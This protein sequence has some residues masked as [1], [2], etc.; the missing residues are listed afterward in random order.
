MKQVSF[1]LGLFLAVCMTLHAASRALIVTGLAA[2]PEDTEEFQ[3]LA[4]ETKRLLVERG[5]PQENIVT[6]PGKVNRD[7][8]LQALQAAQS[9]AKDDEFWLVLY[10]HSGTVDNDEAAFQI[11]GP[12]LTASDLKT[13]LAAIPARQ[14]V[15]IATNSS[16]GFL[17][18]L[19]SSNRNVL[20]ATKG[21]DED[22]QP[23]FPDEWIEA[24]GE[25]PK[26]SFAR[27]AARAATLTEDQY[28]TN[29]LAQTEHA[30]L[31]DATTGTILE[32]PFG[33]DL[34]VKDP[35]TTASSS[36]DKGGQV[37]LS[38]LTIKPHDPN[39]MWEK[40]PASDETRKLIADAQK[41]PNP[42]GDAAIM[43]EQQ[44]GFTVRAD[45]MT[46]RDVAYRVYVPREEAVQ[47]WANCFLPQSAP[48]V[49]TKLI[50]ARVINPDGSSTI[51]NPAKLHES[52]DPESGQSAGEGMIF[53]P[54]AHAGCVI[55][56][57]YRTLQM[58]DSSIPQV[59]ESFP[60][61]QSVPVL[62]TSLEVRVPEKP[63][64]HVQL[65]GLTGRSRGKRGGRAQNFALGI[66]A[67][68]FRR[69]SAG[70]SARRAMD[71]I[72]RSEFAALVGRI[73]RLVP[74]AGPGI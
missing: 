35:T 67:H 74:P 43:L 16:G 14:Y 30:R 18:P 27:I 37:D 6:L 28:K 71:G 32:P 47:D 24:F 49:T 57:A 73:R 68:P 9:S 45:R 54:D 72:P 55:E 15:F 59:S 17:T 64:F 46:E 1:S 23:R 29:S 69:A 33:V 60:I 8:I 22:D 56:I 70:R 52:I 12:R 42:E 50:K 51:F 20:T 19:Q 2:S 58:L 44:I 36:S 38:Q 26:A 25:N 34:S 61:Q 10:G 11:S 5:F 7:A 63:T 3:R 31:A 4:G 65:N 62:K 53:L 21:Q 13:A 41:T 66:G 40:Q 39:A 48:V